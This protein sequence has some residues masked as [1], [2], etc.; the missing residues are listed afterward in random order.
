MVAD[1]HANA[2]GSPYLELFRKQGKEVLLLSN[3]ID[4][5]LVSHLNEYKGKKIVDIAKG[6]VDMEKLSS[7]ED[8]KA[9]KAKAKEAKDLLKRMQDVLGDAVEEVRVS[10]RLVESPSCLVVNENDMGIQ[11]RKILEA[12]GQSMPAGKPI[13]EVN[14]EHALIKRLDTETDEDKFGDL[15]HVL[16]D[17]ARLSAGDDLEDA[18][19]YVRRVNQLL[20]N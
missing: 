1:S 20:S 15:T 13:L 11:M 19:S 4:E 7:K 18:A 9:L 14:P 12:S 16:F 17:Q 8:A 3:S 10:G 2:L 6:D 5:W